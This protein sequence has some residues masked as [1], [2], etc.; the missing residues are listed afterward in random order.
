MPVAD[1]F[2]KVQGRCPACGLSSLFLGSGGYVTCGNLPCPDPCAASRRIEHGK[3]VDQ[4]IA[5]CLANA[6][7]FGERGTG[8]LRGAASHSGAALV[9]AWEDLGLRLVRVAAPVAI[10]SANDASEQRDRVISTDPASRAI[11]NSQEGR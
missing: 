10:D 5:L 2:P 11:E 4:V 3:D 8:S 9:T 6:A 1:G 7:T